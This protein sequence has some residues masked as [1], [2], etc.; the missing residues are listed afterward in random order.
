MNRD[1]QPVF[2]VNR[3][4]ANYK[5]FS[6]D[7]EKEKLG[8]VRRSFQPNSDRQNF[9]SNDRNEFDPITRKITQVTLPEVEDKLD[10]IEQDEKNEN[11][12]FYAKQKTFN[13]FLNESQ[14]N[15]DILN[16]DIL[17]EGKYIGSCVDIGG[18]SRKEVSKYF[19]DATTM[20][21]Y[22]GNPDEDDW[23]KSKELPP[24]EWLKYIDRV[25]V[26]TKAMKGSVS[27]HYIAYSSIGEEMSPEESAIF[28]I[29]NIDQDI[30]YFFKRESNLDI[31]LKLRLAYKKWIESEQPDYFGGDRDQELRLNAFMKELDG[32]SSAET[33]SKFI[34]ALDSQYG[35]IPKRFRSHFLR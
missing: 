19:P 21:M 12:S 33:R 34:K 8:K 24:A 3:K 31:P 35:K 22:V 20:A 10:T 18:N 4:V 17:K 5:D 28:F 29:Y 15:E 13:E 16:E 1:N 6:A 2:N 26:P 30:H 11:K 27:Y 14:I 9:P 32:Y 23:G 25:T 7:V